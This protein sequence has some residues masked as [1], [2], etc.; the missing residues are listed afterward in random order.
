MRLVE[1]KKTKHVRGFLPRATKF[2]KNPS[3]VVNKSD[4]EL[5]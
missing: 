3:F 2:R 1:K 4:H 5:H